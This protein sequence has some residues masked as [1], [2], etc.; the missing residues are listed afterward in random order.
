MQK[1]LLEAAMLVRE[2]GG[3]RLEARVRAPMLQTQE[4]HMTCQGTG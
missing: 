3:N 4:L 1:E 2:G